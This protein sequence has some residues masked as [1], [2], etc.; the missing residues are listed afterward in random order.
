MATQY[1]FGKIVTD[2]LVLCLDAAD[3]NSYVSGSTVWRDVAGSNNGTLTNGP[4]F[5]TGSGGSIVFDGVDDLVNVTTSS[6]YQFTNTDPFTISAWINADKIGEYNTILAY[7][8]GVSDFRGYYLQ[9]VSTASIALAGQRTNSFLFD[10]FE[11]STPSSNWKGIVGDS[12]SITFN[13]WV[14]ITATSATGNDANGMIVYQ[15]ASIVPFQIRRNSSPT[16]VNYAGVPLN[17]GSRG[18][19]Q[20]FKGSIASVQL[21][22]RALSASE[23]LQNY[24]AQK[25]R[26]GL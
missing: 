4:T 25:S 10:Y 19:I 18:G 1:S 16:S 15:N 9:L 22:N 8:L 21:Y 26:F 5:N 14:M 7:S 6:L 13:S 11:G 20:Q 12:N 17:I 2:G 23:V 24:N 3:R